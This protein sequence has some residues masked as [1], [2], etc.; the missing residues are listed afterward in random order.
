MRASQA[1]VALAGPLA[2][3]IGVAGVVTVN[4]LGGG[5]D[6]VW[7][8]TVV[9]GLLLHLT[10]AVRAGWSGWP[11]WSPAVLAVLALVSTVVGVYGFR[12][13]ADLP[14]A[15]RCLCEYVGAAKPARWLA[16]ASAEGHRANLAAACALDPALGD[17]LKTLV[18]GK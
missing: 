6:V 13:C 3:A 18:P 7:M 1:G 9:A 16:P 8:L 17:V 15:Q 14:E 10:M 5:S 4:R 11:R 12:T 2:V